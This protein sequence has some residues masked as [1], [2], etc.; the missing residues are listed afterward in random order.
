MSNQNTFIFGLILVLVA[1]VLFGQSCT[2]KSIIADEFTS[3]SKTDSEES[4]SG[5]YNYFYMRYM[6]PYPLP[7]IKFFSND[8]Q[9]QLEPNQNY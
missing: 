6:N 2:K 9:K 4:N 3:V 7:L 5:L 1:I 8:T